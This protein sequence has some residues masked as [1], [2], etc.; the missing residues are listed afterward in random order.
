LEEALGSSPARDQITAALSGALAHEL[1]THVER[2]EFS[3]EE[4]A[5]A[6]ER[7]AIL[8]A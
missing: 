1:A 4:V 7:V 2:E 5:M 8:A 6:N 3:E